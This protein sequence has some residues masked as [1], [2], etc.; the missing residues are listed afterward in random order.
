MI[1]LDTIGTLYDVD[2][3]DP[4][5]PISTPL[6][7]FHVNTDHPIE[8]AEQYR[9]VPNSPSRVFAGADTLFYSF[10]DEDTFKG[11]FP[12]LYPPEPEVL[13]DEIQA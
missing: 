11:F 5:N 4:E 6:D 13:P 10:P 9:V 2:L 12:E 1:N 8:G 3:S 7:G